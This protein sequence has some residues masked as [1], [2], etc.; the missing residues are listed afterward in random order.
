MKMIHSPLLFLSS[1]FYKSPLADSFQEL[2]LSHFRRWVGT[3]C[4]SVAFHL[5]AVES[6]VRAEFLDRIVA[7][8]AK[9]LES[10]TPVEFVAL[11]LIVYLR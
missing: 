2:C 1:E 11:A 3:T 10:L 4:L 6:E 9:D 7:R 5:H 8:M